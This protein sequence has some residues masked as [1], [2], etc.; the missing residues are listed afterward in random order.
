MWWP[1]SGEGAAARSDVRG[2]AQGG[3]SNLDHG[4]HRAGCPPP[5]PAARNGGG[6]RPKSIPVRSGYGLFHFLFFRTD[7][8]VTIYWRRL[9]MPASINSFCPPPIRFMYLVKST[10]NI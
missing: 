9:P 2:C 6:V 1:C 3:S 5:A 4:T 7:L 10:Q 8:M